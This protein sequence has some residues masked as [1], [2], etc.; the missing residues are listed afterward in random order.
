M[1]EIENMND[2][3]EGT[4]VT[5]LHTPT[6]VVDVSIEHNGKF[7]K[8]QFVRLSWKENLELASEMQEQKSNTRTGVTTTVVNYWKYLTTTYNRTVKKSPDGFRFD[9]CSME[10]GEKLIKAMPGVAELMAPE[11]LDD[12]E[13]KN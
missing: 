9:K 1:S 8:F 10:F 13:I 7:W 5:E 12:E 4:D 3:P 6:E 11:N 2:L